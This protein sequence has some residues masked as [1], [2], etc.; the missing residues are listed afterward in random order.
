MIT[1]KMLTLMVLVTFTFSAQAEQSWWQQLLSAVGLGDTEAVT[2]QATEAANSI[3]IDGLVEMLTSNLGVTTEQAQGGIAAL[4]NFAKQNISEEQ[5]MSLSEQIPGL[6][7]VMRYLPSISST[8]Q[9]GLGGLLSMA[10]NFNEQLG[11]LGDLKQQFDTLGLDSNMITQF[12][13]QA[14]SYLDSPEGA[15]AKQ[16]LSESLENLVI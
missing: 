2:Q 13:E 14:R 10:G 7:S 12:A 9:D 3:D 16:I 8:K 11:Q 4:M 15:E 6:D 1:K 5:F